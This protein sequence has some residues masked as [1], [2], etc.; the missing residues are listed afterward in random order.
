MARVN[1][2]LHKIGA[3]ETGTC[4]C[5]Q[6]EETVDHFLFLYPRWDE[7]QEHMRNVDQGIMGNLSFFLGGKS[8]EDGHKWSPNLV[9]VLA[10]I[11]FTINTGRLD[12][13]QT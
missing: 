4:D 2:Y 13:T 6:E 10:A 12:A 9:A 5:G 7:Q 3:A 8:A 11:K 1:R